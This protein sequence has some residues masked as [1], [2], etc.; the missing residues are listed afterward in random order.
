VQ[1]HN[2]KLQEALIGLN[3]RQAAA[4]GD[5]GALGGKFRDLRGRKD[6]AYTQ[7]DAKDIIDRNNADENA[8][9]MRLAER[10]IQQQD[11]AVTS[12]AA[13]R[14]TIPEQGRMLTFKRAVVVDTWADLNLRLALAAAKTASWSVRL[15]ILAATALVLVILA[16]ASR[17]V[18]GAP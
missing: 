10:L 13:L 1:L 8:A 15:L 7:Q 5:P 6:V 18:R 11:A 12:P 17:L 2:L 3:V 9:F 16:R 4:A 14:A